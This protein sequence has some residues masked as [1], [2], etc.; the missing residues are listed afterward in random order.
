MHDILTQSHGFSR[1]LLLPHISYIA[2]TITA[3]SLSLYGVALYNNLYMILV[4]D[5]KIN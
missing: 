2:Y 3:S 1:F 5:L 4:T